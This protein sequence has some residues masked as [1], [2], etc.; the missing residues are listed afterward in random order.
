MN[1]SPRLTRSSTDR[2]IAGV[3]GGVANYLGVDP[4]LVRLG[5]VL[6]VL[7]GGLSP[8]IYVILWAVLPTEKSANQAFTQQVRENIAEIEQ[9]ATQIASKVSSQV[10]QLV[11]NDQ[12]RTVGQSTPSTPPQ[13][14]DGPATGPTRRL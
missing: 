14:D 6:L 9:Q 10:G 2:I 4:T 12:T 7:V 13:H 11:G 5:F 3:A 1:T 8:L